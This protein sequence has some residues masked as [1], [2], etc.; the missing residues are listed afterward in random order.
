MS[1]LTVED[2]LKCLAKHRQ[3]KKFMHKTK[4]GKNLGEE[5]GYDRQAHTEHYQR[6][7]N[8]PYDIKRWEQ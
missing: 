7:K 2:C 8:T 3:K 1:G 5:F 4:Y 6:I